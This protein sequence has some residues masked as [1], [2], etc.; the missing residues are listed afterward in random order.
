MKRWLLAHLPLAALV[1]L[2]TLW[3]LWLVLAY[4]L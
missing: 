4:A 3:H 1:L 2:L